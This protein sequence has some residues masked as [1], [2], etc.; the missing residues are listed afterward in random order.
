[1]QWQAAESRCKG[2]PKRA[3]FFLQLERTAAL[4]KYKIMFNLRPLFEPILWFMKPYPIGGTLTDNII[5]YEVGGYNE[6]AL[7]NSETLN[8]GLEICSNIL[9]V[10]TE[11]SDR[12]LHPTQKAVSLKA[13]R[14]GQPFHFSSF[15][16]LAIARWQLLCA[17]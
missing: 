7:K 12:G 1:M 15:L 6:Y 11:S 14:F 5:N 16:P 10:K 8:S 4:K 9:K 2:C 3:A 17:R 13:A